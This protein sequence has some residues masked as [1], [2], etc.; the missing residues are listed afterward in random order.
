SGDLFGPGPT[1]DHKFTHA[2][3]ITYYCNIHGFD[4]GD[5]T[6]EGMVGQITVIAPEWSHDGSGDWNT[7]GNWSGGV[8]NGLDARAN[9][10]G[11]IHV[12]K[13]ISTAT[14]IVLGSIKFDNANSYEIAGA[15]SLASLALQV[16]TGSASVLVQQGSHKLNLPLTFASNAQVTVASG[17]LT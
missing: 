4:V 14:S 1:F 6:A 15:G 7:A 9:F 12:P 16:S 17:A 13:T 11:A 3:V 5:G 10:L 2:G 8:P